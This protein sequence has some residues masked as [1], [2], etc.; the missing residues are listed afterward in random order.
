M[1]HDPSTQH[2]NSTK[3]DTQVMNH[4]VQTCLEACGTC[5]DMCLQTIQH[6]LSYGAA[7]A[8]MVPLL[9]DCV[10]ICATSKNFM[11]RGS[12]QDALLCGIC[13]H[14]CE[15]CAAS[16]SASHD[17]DDRMKSCAE[18]CRQCAETCRKMV[19]LV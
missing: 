7:H 17:S 16:C 14:I 11:L 15:L 9:M 19:A 4:A 10:D 18:T 2:Y 6:C 3:H 8:E 5:H 12:R 1:T 13:A